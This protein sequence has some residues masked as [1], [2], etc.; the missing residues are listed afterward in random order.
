MEHNFKL[1]LALL[2]AVVMAFSAAAC[3]KAIPAVTSSNFDASS[4]DNVTSEFDDIETSS[5]EEIYSETDY[6]E[7]EDYTSSGMESV[8]IEVNSDDLTE[9]SI[10]EDPI[11]YEELYINN[12]VEPINDNFLGINGVHMGFGFMPDIYNRNPLEPWQLKEEYDRIAYKMRIKQIRTYYS[13]AIVWD[14]NAKKLEWDVNKNPYLNG[15]YDSL[16]AWQERGVE[17]AMSAQWSLDA[18]IGT[19]YTSD[20]IHS[21]A[22]HG[23]YIENDLDTTLKNYRSFIKQSVL[24]LQANGINNVKYLLAFTEANRTLGGGPVEN[25]RY[26][27]VCALYD[28]AINALVDG[29][30]DAGMRKSYKIVGPLDNFRNDFEYTDPEQYSTMVKY[31][32]ENLSDKVDIIGTHQYVNSNEF[33]NDS[34]YY[35]VQTSL[36]K[37]K[38]MVDKAGKEIWIDEFNAILSSSANATLNSEESQANLHNPIAGVATAATVNGILNYGMDNVFFWSMTDMMWSDNA[39]ISYEFN[40]GLQVSGFMPTPLESMTPYYKWYSLSLLSRYIGKGQVYETVEGYSVYI[41]CIKRT[42][43]EWTVV[44][45]NYNILDTPIHINFE[46]S[47]GGKTF[48]RHLY[49]INNIVPTEEA[50]IIGVSARAT[51]VT[52]GFYDTL[53][54]YSVAVYTTDKD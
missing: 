2:L 14:F 37:T 5:E 32:L 21:F 45:T 31:T 48:Y 35:Q 53:P 36:G 50:E 12:N 11:F 26:D 10:E 33:S 3:K 30:N 46:K 42:D 52:T 34:Y 13:S 18:F 22:G 40:Q 27:E 7:S 43:G 16:K 39:T 24:N 4:S 51:D 20:G 38:D 47:M 44:V 54:G 29:L 23:W 15:F 1:L 28:K 6:T 49:D 25:R 8:D 19:A 41:S 17:V 9:P